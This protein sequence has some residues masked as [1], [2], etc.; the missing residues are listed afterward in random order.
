ML[1]CSDCRGQGASFRVTR[2]NPRWAHV[3]RQGPRRTQVLHCCVAITITTQQRVKMPVCNLYP[4]LGSFIITQTWKIE[5]SVGM[6][7]W[8]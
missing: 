5:A 6:H 1:W 4:L 3:G 2:L 8:R 7:T